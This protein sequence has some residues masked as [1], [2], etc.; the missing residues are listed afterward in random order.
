MSGAIACEQ[1]QY[2]TYVLSLTEPN[3]SIEIVPAR[4]GILTRWQFQG[5]DIFYLDHERFTDPS[6]S[7]RGGNPILFPICGNLPDNTYTY[8][9]Q[10]YTLKQ[11][12][13][14]RDLPWQVVEQPM[15]DCPSI[16]LRLKSNQQ[17]REVYPFDFELL[18][19]YTLHEDLL[20]T[21]Q[22][23][24][25]HSDD[26][27]MPFAL[28][29]HPYFG[30]QDKQKLEFEIPSE[31]FQD[32]QTKEVHPFKG[33]FDLER[34]ELD[35]IFQTLSQNTATIVDR[36]QGTRLKLEFSHA[37]ANLVFWT[38][39]G[40]DFYCLEPWTAPRNAMNTGDRLLYLDPGASFETSVNFYIE[41][42]E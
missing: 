4:G 9:G 35:L 42:L 22:T 11:H 25:N 7:V 13:F 15:G 18:F 17:T 26:H 37:Y 40:K 24:I 34:D 38:L 8:N 36:H 31:E 1:R 29:F 23:I 5:K 20:A 19:R 21:E 3:S 27:P 41:L 2:E 28:G 12:G 16:L 14:A 32:Q 33:D 6:L 30:V 39:K 10:S